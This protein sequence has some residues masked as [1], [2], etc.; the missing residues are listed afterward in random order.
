MR[1]KRNASAT[2]Y[3]HVTARGNGRQ[4]LF[5]SDRDRRKFLELLER[6]GNDYSVALI[7]WCLMDNHVHL[8]VR[9]E[10]DDLSRAMLRVC[11]SYASYFNGRTGHVGHVFQGRFHSEP[12]E[13]DSHLLEA[14]RYIHANPEDMQ[15][16]L[17]Q[18]YKWSSYHEYLEEGGGLVDTSL[19][20]DMLG[21]VERFEAFHASKLTT[22]PAYMRKRLTSE[23]AR[24][25]ADETLGAGVAATLKSHPK[26]Q[27][28]KALHELRAAGLSIRQIERITG[29]GRGVIAKC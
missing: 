15:K 12:I 10:V 9:A 25:I 13:K 8:L 26:P 18:S 11:G 27:R 16:G 14:V 2:G 20:L 23:D 17:S 5:E 7:A 24:V 29:I 1:A 19:I 21:G 22:V 4:L 6:A 28:D 3:Y